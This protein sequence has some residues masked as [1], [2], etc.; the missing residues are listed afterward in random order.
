MDDFSAAAQVTF[1]RLGGRLNEVTGYHEIESL[2]K[3][4]AENEHKMHEIRE[5]TRAAKSAYE[6]AVSRRSNSQ[7]EVNDLLQRKSSWTD[8]DVSRFTQLVRQDHLVEQEEVRAKAVAES[9]DDAVE[10]QF[11][12]L[13]RAILA[14]YHEEQVWSDKIRSASTYGSLA[15]LGLNLAVF[16]LAIVLVEP[17]KRKRLV[18]SFEKR[19]VE[20]NEENQRV[21]ERGL[22]DLKL[23]QAAQEALLVEMHAAAA[24]L[25]RAELPIPAVTVTVREGEGSAEV[26]VVSVSPPIEFEQ[27]AKAARDR[28]IMAVSAA[29]GA[30]GVGI[31]GFVLGSWCS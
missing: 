26:D 1:H 28:Q 15:A 11:N 9:A 18:Q 16:V 25:A 2:K 31:A 5:Q 10:R 17:W 13:M 19:V 27:R 8:A 14:R 22:N 21:V 12:E 23:R 24:A 7:R 30:V 6:D 3:L 20:L 4:V 29:V